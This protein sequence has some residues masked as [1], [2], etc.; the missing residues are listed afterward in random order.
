MVSLKMTPAEAKSEGYASPAEMK[1]PEY[2][3][4]TRL[5]LVDEA[6]KA[7]FPKMPVVGST[8]AVTGAAIISSVNIVQQE[9]GDTRVSIEL[10]MT[11]IDARAVEEKKS[12]AET[13]Y[14]SED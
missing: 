2:P 13:L 9:G 14:P 11:D 1:A 6:A 8:V 12:A 4:G 5:T 3:W 10:Q 7:L